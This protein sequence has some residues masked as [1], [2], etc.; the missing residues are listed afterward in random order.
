MLILCWILS[1]REVT[2]YRYAM[3]SEP[4]NDSLIKW[5]FILGRITAIVIP[6]VACSLSGEWIYFVAIAMMIPLCHVIEKK[7]APTRDHIE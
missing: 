5:Q 7:W 3:N 4:P 1:S 6:L 2:S